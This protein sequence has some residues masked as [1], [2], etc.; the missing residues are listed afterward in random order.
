MNN[1]CP[2]LG[3]RRPDV[4]TIL[5]SRAAPPSRVTNETAG[6]LALTV[7][8]DLKFH[9][10]VEPA[11]RDGMGR[12]ELKIKT[13]CLR[14]YFFLVLEHGHEF[15]AGVLVGIIE[16]H[17]LLFRQFLPSASSR[18]TSALSSPLPVPA[19]AACSRIRSPSSGAHCHCCPSKTASGC[20]LRIRRVSL[21]ASTLMPLP[22]A[23]RTEPH[24][25]TRLPPASGRPSSTFGSLRRPVE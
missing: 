19:R 6:I 23:C 11:N 1:F 15:P 2:K 3:T 21:S 5:A 25:G 8:C 14:P 24:C 22:L 17:N 18:Q 4:A 9:K 13:V 12:F 10:P 20:G 7:P 16:R